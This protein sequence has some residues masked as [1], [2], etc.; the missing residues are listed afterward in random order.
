MMHKQFLP[1]NY[2]RDLYHI[3]LSLNQGRLSVEE[4]IRKFEQL[5]IKS[6][7]E[8]E[9]EQTMVR[10]LRGLDPGRVEKVDI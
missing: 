5:Q 1:D 7:I 10:F 8:E 6:G 4:Y 2:K 9:P 3:V